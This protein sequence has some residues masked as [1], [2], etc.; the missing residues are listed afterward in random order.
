MM[1]TYIKLYQKMREDYYKEWG[2]YADPINMQEFEE[3]NH[4]IYE[5]FLKDKNFSVGKLKNYINLLL[6]DIRYFGYYI[7]FLDDD[8][9]RLND[10]IW[11]H[12]RTELLSDGTTGAGT[13]Y[14]GSLVEDLLICFAC[15]DFSVIKSFVPETTPLLNDRFYPH[16]MINLFSAVYYKD[17]DKLEQAILLAESY[18]KKKISGLAEYYVR[19]FLALAVEDADGLSECL[20][21]LCEAYQRQGYPKQKID[22]CFAPEIH[23]LYRLIRF[24]DEEL[25]RK[26]QMPTHKCFLKEFE[27]W[28]Q[29]NDYPIGKQFYHYPKELEEA[30]LLLQKPLP[31]I[32]L[33]KSDGKWLPDINKFADE[34]AN[35][36]FPF[37]CD[38]NTA[39]LTCC[40][41]LSKE[42]PVLY[43]SHDEDG[44][45]QF[46][47]GRT[48]EANEAKLVSLKSMLILDS[49]IRD[50]ADMPC[51]CVAERNSKEDHWLIRKE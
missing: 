6:Q 3:A 8:F 13:A 25:F 42:E 9:E 22:K 45:W 26:V 24:L 34:L 31:V 14:S 21:K 35:F 27:E 10:I 32:H 28:Q 30:N 46:L 38:E 29:K 44:T 41:I 40:H 37:A 2:T 33:R 18:L 5:K 49:S 16:N 36:E 48:H 23:G 19:F 20:Q 1:Q 17:K 43:V 47:C 12:G 50:L 11:Q 39:V 7:A 15:N 51:G 4:H